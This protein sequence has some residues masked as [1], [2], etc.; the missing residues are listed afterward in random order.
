MLIEFKYRPFMRICLQRKEV[1]GGERRRKFVSHTAIYGQAI[2]FVLKPR[3]K[4]GGS[5]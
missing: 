4:T 5:L 2:K 3:L 1:R